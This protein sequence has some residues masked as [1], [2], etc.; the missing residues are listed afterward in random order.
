MVDANF[1]A[2][3]PDNYQLP[4]RVSMWF[5]KKG[6]SDEADWKEFGNIIDPSIA[7]QIERLDHFSQRRGARAKDRSEISSR[8]TQINFSID[9]LN[10]HNL[11]FAFGSIVDPTDDTLEVH[12]SKTVT[13]PGGTAPDNE[14]SLGENDITDGSLIVRSS[15]LEDE[16][17]YTEDTDYTVDYATGILTILPGGALNDASEETGVPQLHA[18]YTRNVETQSFTCFDG[19]E[20]EGEC[21]FQVLTKAGMQYVLKANRC[22]V[23]NNGDFT[24]GDGQDWQKVALTVDILVDDDGNLVTSH[25]INDKELD[26]E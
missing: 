8:A 22:T 17:T 10:L 24:I 19:T 5:R 20:I 25:K 18:K 6:S 2:A 7:P 12:D 3:N 15:N 11:Q 26:I 9:E 4:G 23:K 14:V 13:N 16:V 1:R 21:Q